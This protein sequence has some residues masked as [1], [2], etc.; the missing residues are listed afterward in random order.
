MVEN[1]KSNCQ[2]GFVCCAQTQFPC[3][4]AATG[5]KGNMIQSLGEEG[6]AFS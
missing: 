6:A 4:D 1:F 2:A 5:V 3:Q